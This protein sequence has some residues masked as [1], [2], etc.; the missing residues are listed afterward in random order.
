L[1]LILRCGATVPDLFAQTSLTGTG[2]WLCDSGS[3][4]EEL[5]AGWVALAAALPVDVGDIELALGL[6]R[7]MRSVI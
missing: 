2:P 7:A 6:S 1:Y 3:G 5:L 4:G